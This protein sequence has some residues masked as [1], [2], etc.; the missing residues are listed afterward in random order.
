[1]AYLR[2]AIQDDSRPNLINTASSVPGCYEDYVTSLKERY[3]RKRRIH[4]HHT[5][6]LFNCKPCKDSSA[7]EL[8]RVHTT[9]NNAVKRL[10]F[11]GQFTAE[12]I[13]TFFAEGLLPPDLWE[14][15]NLAE[16]DP[17]VVPKVNTLLQFL[18][19]RANLAQLKAADLGARNW[20]P[21]TERPRYPQRIPTKPEDTVIRRQN[22]TT[23]QGRM[24]LLCKEEQHP[25]FY[26]EAF[27]GMTVDERADYVRQKKLCFNCLSHGH[28]TR[29]CISMYRC[30]RC[31]KAHHSTL[32]RG[33]TE[34]VE[35]VPE[36]ERRVFAVAEVVNRGVHSPGVFLPTLLLTAHGPDHRS[37]E[38]RAMMDG[39][40][41]ISLMKASVA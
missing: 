5:R 35:E 6:T 22:Y 4:S 32:H 33:P 2:K 37:V 24:C 25:L 34:E 38:V 20:E 1:M 12:T 36:T 10:E 13:L 3:D 8:T 26:C 23:S 18:E 15:W 40:S 11:I 16:G 27:K 29:D 28:G 17:Q 19:R 14:Q 7:N 30:K 21:P 41:T 39:G 9:L 31:G